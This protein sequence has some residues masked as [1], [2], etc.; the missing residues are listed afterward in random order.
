MA[1][2]KNRH[3]RL[4]GSAPQVERAPKRSVESRVTVTWSI[5]SAV[6]ATQLVH[7]TGS[8]QR[9]PRRL[10]DH[11]EGSQRVL[12]GNR[13]LVTVVHPGADVQWCR[14]GAVQVRYRRSRAVFGVDRRTRPWRP[15]AASL[16]HLAVSLAGVEISPA[17]QIANADP[18]ACCGPDTTG[19]AILRLIPKTAGTIVFDG[20][21]LDTLHGVAL[22]KARRRLQ[23]VFQ[24]PYGS[25][26]PRMTVEEALTEAMR[27]HRLGADR[28]ERRERAIKLLDEV[29]LSRTSLGRYPHEFSGGQRQRIG[30]ARALSVEPDLVICD[31]SVSALDVSVQAQVLNLLKDLQEHRGLTYV[32]ISHDLSVVK[33]MSDMLV[34]MQAGKVVEYGPSDSVYREPRQDYTR[35]LIDSI[36]SDSLADIRRRQTERRADVVQEQ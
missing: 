17:F 7:L 26:N 36:P 2:L 4:G 33:F 16:A 22:R 19:R 23:V 28:S 5:Q 30:I 15:S 34:V 3:A 31:E 8:N 13:A 1:A 12:D 11:V 14:T 25:L 21:D 29:G 20:V 35:R 32:F 10:G 6:N 24:D 27:I 9:R 18:S